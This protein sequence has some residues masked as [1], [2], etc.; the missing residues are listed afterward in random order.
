[1]ADRRISQLTSANTLV[2]SDLVPF[3]D[4]SATET[5]RITA[6]N[7]GLALL[8]FGTTRGSTT[9]T[10]PANGQLW[11][12]TS[13][14]PPE[15]KIYNG[16]AWSLV[17]F[18]PSSAVITNPSG[19]QP[20]SPVLG[21]LWLDT[22]QTPDELKV[23]DGSSFVRVDPLG[24]TEAAGDARYLQPGTAA[25]T[26]LPLA[27]GTLTGTL[28]L[29]ADPTANLHAATKQYVDAEI[30]NSESNVTPIANG[31]TGQTTATGAINALL[32][33]QTG[34]SGEYLTTDGTNVS[35]TPI[36]GGGLLRNPQL[37]TSGTS[38]TTPANCTKIYVEIVGGGQGGSGG[39]R[40]TEGAGGVAGGFCARFFTVTA[41]TSY[42]YAIGAGGTAGAQGFAGGDGGNTTFAV[43]ATTLTAYG[44]ATSQSVPV[45]G[46]IN[47]YGESG[48]AASLGT[49]GGRGGGSYF[50]GGG[51]GATTGAG[52][53]G[54]NGSGGGGGATGAGGAGG[55]GM[56]RIWEYA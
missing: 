51:A 17:S 2:E 30:A 5:K 7:L 49:A 26:Y 21:Q 45:N 29:D 14:N 27:G 33:S 37:L 13:N 8:A 53:A 56:I 32:P 10:S 1:M 20:A 28:T 38:Y 12:D 39:F 3:V 47:R 36:T 50:Q 31:G 6:E 43:G 34:N 4:I 52:S 16:A 55:S 11:V 44:G 9:P 41:S 40:F 23:Y 42:T 48:L 22:S 24:I 25:S 18:L 54:L 15:L 46:D 19:T 35:W